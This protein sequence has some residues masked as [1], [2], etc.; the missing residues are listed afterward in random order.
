MN[1]FND[2]VMNE[3]NLSTIIKA[4]I[5]LRIWNLLTERVTRILRIKL[6]RE[7]LG[8]NPQLVLQNL[9]SILMEDLK[10]SFELFRN[11]Y[12][13]V[14]EYTTVDNLNILISNL[15]NF[16]GDIKKLKLLINKHFQEF[17]EDINLEGDLKKDT[18][19]CVKFYQY[20]L[21]NNAFNTRIYS[22]L[23]FIHREFLG[24]HLHSAY[25]FIRALSNLDNQKIKDNL[26]KDFTNIRKEF[27]KREY[28]IT[29]SPTMLRNDM[30]YLYWIYYRIIGILYMNIDID[31]L[32]NLE[33]NLLLIVEKMLVF[34][35]SVP[36]NVKFN[37]EINGQLEQFLILA[38]FNF[39]Q[40]L[41]NMGD[42]NTPEKIIIPEAKGF[43]PWS[44]YNH[45]LLKDVGDNIKPGFR[46]SVSFIRNLTRTIL[47]NANE[48]N[49]SFVEKYL[50]VLF[51]WFSI[52]YDIYNLL[53][54]D[55]MKEILSYIAWVL[56]KELEQNLYKEIL[57]LKMNKI[58]PI[59]AT[60]NGFLPFT[61]FFELNGKKDILK[62]EDIKEMTLLT[63]LALQH[64]LLSFNIQPKFNEALNAKFFPRSVIKETNISEYDTNQVLKDKL[65]N[66]RMPI[67]LNVKKVK[68]LIL[69]DASNIAMRHGDKTFSTKGI[70][71]V[72]DYFTK[73]G[74]R[75]LAFLPEYLFRENVST[76][77]KRVVPD[78]IEYLKKLYSEG[79]IV[80]TPPQDYDDSYCIQYCRQNNAFIVTNDLF[81]DYLEKFNDGIKKK[82]EN[83][84]IIEKRISFTFVKDEFLPNPDCA[85]FKEFSIDEY[86]KNATEN[87]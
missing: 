83:L 71:I 1:F 26:E 53:I 24:D 77:K 46:Y 47:A 14:T 60:F 31:L 79:L 30:D 68:P 17:K 23:G 65:Q 7:H 42:K 52:N 12:V 10:N 51:Y 45:N 74:H 80:Q 72:M 67:Q 87:K 27:L 22:N 62:V 58:L 63:K 18:S 64:F 84:W 25:W 32:D 16:M 2:L 44:I 39:H 9:Y 81:R 61:K 43:L 85:F 75:V 57:M 50:A 56:N 37:F 76:S 4:N 33:R 3:K 34:Y 82:T 55:D 54:E 28:E 20:A 35:P 21:N 13:I 69:L 41:N 36:D 49:F 15:L 11:V 78:D 48:T 6:S 8:K 5:D 70:M 86:S 40:N 66:T 59:E 19:D 73:N 29:N 38:I